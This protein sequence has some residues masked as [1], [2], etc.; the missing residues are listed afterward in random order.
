[1]LG[2][3]LF[4]LSKPHAFSG[5]GNWISQSI[6]PLVSANQMNDF[7]PIDPVTDLHLFVPAIGHAHQSATA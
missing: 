5:F 3:Y 6:T 2:G 1:V 4:A 7:T